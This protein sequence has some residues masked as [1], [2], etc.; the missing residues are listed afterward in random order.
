M[1]IELR[2]LAGRRRP[3]KRQ[4]LVDPAE[5]TGIETLADQLEMTLSE[6]VTL[7]IDN[8]FRDA[9]KPTTATKLRAKA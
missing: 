3:R 5:A 9:P 2:P 1:T 7:A 4:L 6:L 8:F